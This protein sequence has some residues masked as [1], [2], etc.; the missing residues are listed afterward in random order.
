MWTGR[1]RV[2]NS[3]RARRSAICPGEAGCPHPSQAIESGEG[4]S[5]CVSYRTPNMRARGLASLG[6]RIFTQPGTRARRRKCPPPK[7]RAPAIPIY[8]VDGRTRIGG[9]APFPAQVA[10][11]GGSRGGSQAANLSKPRLLTVAQHGPGKEVA[12]EF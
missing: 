7:R 8:E 4:P 5:I 12:R 2:A 10:W 3:S 6:K 9:G 11:P 1:K